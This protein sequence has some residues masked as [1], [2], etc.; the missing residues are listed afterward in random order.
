[1]IPTTFRLAVRRLL[2]QKLNTAL[3]IAGLTLGISVCLLIGLFLRYELSFDN[4]H[5]RADQT[6]RINSIWINA[7]EKSYAYS[8]PVPLAEE[9]RRTVSGL[10]VAALAHP[11][12][13]SNSVIEVDDQRRFRQEH[14]L[15]VEPD[16]LDIFRIE[17]VTGD[18]NAILRKPYHA[19]LTQKAAKKLFG[20]DGPVGRTFLF[21]NKFNITVGGIIKDIPPNSHQSASIL[22]SYVP[23]KDYI[24]TDLATWTSISGTATYV[25]LRNGYSQRDLQAQLDSIANKYMNN[26]GDA[27]ANVFRAELDSQPMRAIHFDSKYLGSEW[28]SAIDVTWLWFFAA[29]GL[30]VLMLA[31]INFVNLSTAQA[32]NRAREV[33]VLKSVG[34][35]RWQLMSNFLLEA[36]MLAAI[37]GI[38]SVGIAQFSLPYMNTILNKQ[39]S[40]DL[41]LS[42]VLMGCLVAGTIITG[43]FA[44]VYPAYLISRFNPAVTLKSGTSGISTGGTPFLRRALLVT[45]FTISVAL[46]I[47]V[48]IISRQLDFMRSRSLGFDRENVINVPIN[49]AGKSAAYRA[50]LEKIPGVADVAFATS[51]PTAAGHWG[52]MMS[53]DDSPDTKREFVTMLLV[54]DHYCNLYGLT[55]ISGR[56]PQPQDTA[57]SSDRLPR[58]Q[59]VVKAVVNETLIRTLGF[60]SAESAL[61]QRFWI[62]MNSGNAEIAGVVADFNTRSLHKAIQPAIL[63]T[64][65]GNA[66]HAGIKLARGSDVMKVLAAVESGWRKVFPDGI[67]EFSFLDA[68]I[69]AFYKSEANLYALF[70]IFAGIA[71]IISCM[72]LWGLSTY[73]AQQ[74]TKE[75]GIRK[76]LGASVRAIVT[77]LSRD[78]LW[79]VVL[80]VAVAVPLSYYFLNDWLQ[81]FAFH[82]SIGW[83]VFAVS[84]MASVIIAALTVSVQAIRAATMNPT[85]ALRSD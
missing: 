84:A 75:I 49:N 10:E 50:E 14:M 34:A 64:D 83:D 44:G 2:R 17:G 72:G 19:L 43:L 33:G 65:Y 26:S 79:L 41:F 22:L 42:P 28:V 30:A 1:M 60:E 73:S 16:F 35:A 13:E 74:R 6:Y 53:R 48:I 47:T 24:G 12:W 58:E 59:Q 81:Q 57:Y 40:F 36:W 21:R 31:C 3:H 11:V 61:G 56:F 67:Y 9:L 23:D 25:V 39:V 27:R 52:T 77:L 7:G 46:L 82:V 51:T 8:T 66:S 38:L 54:D 70:R 32:L 78:F 69:D 37:A 71:M 15:I 62:G 18:P 76:V 85:D 29:I 20:N 4:Y 80:S 55:L 68:Q 5:P 45:Q 63:I